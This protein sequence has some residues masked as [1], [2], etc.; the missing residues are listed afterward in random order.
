MAEVLANLATTTLSA[1]M[2]SGALSCTVTSGA[3]FP[4][5]GNFRIRIGN[6]IIIVGARS[7]NTLS[8]LTRGAEGS[9][10]A[11]H[12]I[13]DLT[14]MVLTRD[15]LTTFVQENAGALGAI[16][17][18]L[19]NMDQVDADALVAITSVGRA[20]VQAADPA[21][22]RSAI[23]AQDASTA[24][25]D[26]ELAVAKRNAL[27]S[28]K[29]GTYALTTAD[30]G[31]TIDATGALT[32]TVPSGLATQVGDWFRVRASSSSLVVINRGGSVEFFAPGSTVARTSYTADYVNQELVFTCRSLGSGGANDWVIRGVADPGVGNIIEAALD[33]DNFGAVP[34]SGFAATND[35]VFASVSATAK[36]ASDAGRTA[37]IVVKQGKLYEFST[38]WQF[39][40]RTH[41]QR[42]GDLRYL[43][44]QDRT[45][46]ALVFR[47]GTGAQVT[48][49]AQ[50]GG[51]SGYGRL[52]CCRR[53][54][55]GVKVD[56]WRN[57][58]WQ[59]GEIVDPCDHAILVCCTGNAFTVSTDANVWRKIRLAVD[60]NKV[61][62][63]TGFGIGGDT[64]AVDQYDQRPRGFI[65][66]TNSTETYNGQQ[67]SSGL[68]VIS[69]SHVEYC[70]CAGGLRPE[71]SPGAD[72]GA[73]A[74]DQTD[75]SRFEYLG[76]EWYSHFE[77][78]IAGGPPSV[79]WNV[80]YLFRSRDENCSRNRVIDPYVESTTQSPNTPHANW[81]F[82]FIRLALT[83]TGANLR[84]VE[85][86]QI[87]GGSFDNNSAAGNKRVMRMINNSPASPGT[88]GN[89]RIIR[90][91]AWLRPEGPFHSTSV[92]EL[93]GAVTDPAAFTL[94]DG[95]EE[96]RIEVLTDGEVGMWTIAGVANPPSG[97][98]KNR[99]VSLSGNAD[100]LSR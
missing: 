13:G 4:T 35:P 97:T 72:D 80:G 93:G 17:D 73:R 47:K 12:T 29:S 83:A 64:D 85:F 46:A 60:A 43:G 7:G 53:V 69:D 44:A 48:N 45:K 36:V 20:L 51:M 63:P 70:W 41:L 8:S 52:F 28:G 38:P 10:A 26:A 86:N 58:E 49:Q 99:M 65:K 31:T 25:T 22:A 96:N 23:G 89:R 6:E 5:S 27:E 84:M 24:A 39:D 9:T 77:R 67:L 32:I 75:A 100:S 88:A 37:E 82:D 19:D 56:G 92:N 59:Q 40:D 68:S 61:G 14:K 76:C 15:G 34:G 3:A 66:V 55:W 57:G 21:A 54:G 71:S 30:L 50:G 33:P 95:C 81:E 11:P 78:P 18:T 87:M 2:T 42:D 90:R 98:R 74:V 91:N 94:S 62:W 16:L 79:M 1:N